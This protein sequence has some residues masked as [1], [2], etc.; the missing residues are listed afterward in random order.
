MKIQQNIYVNFY[1][2]TSKLLFSLACLACFSNLAIANSLENIAFSSMPG[3]KIQ[4]KMEFSEQAPDPKIFTIDVPARIVLDFKDTSLKLKKKKQR[5]GVGMARSVKAVESQGR[6]RVV[7]NLTSLT[8]YKTRIKNNILYLTLNKGNVGSNKY[9]TQQSI[10]DIDFR[11]GSNGE[12]HIIISFNNKIDNI[13][14]RDKGG[15]IVVNMQNVN[16]PQDLERRLDVVDFATPVQLIDT[17][18]Q[19]NGVRMVIDAKGEYDHLG[20]QM[21]NQFTIEIKELTKKQKEAKLKARFGYSGERLSLIFQDIEVRA[22]L[23]LIADFTGKNMVT[24]D[25]V[26]G[27]ITLRLK[28]VPWDQALDLILKTKGLAMREEGNVIRVAPMEELAAIEKQELEANKTIASLLPRVRETIQLNYRRASVV[29]ALL[30]SIGD[31][32]GSKNTASS[33]AGEA[34]TGGDSDSGASLL[35]ANATIIGDDRTNKIIVYDNR[36]NIVQLRKLI[37]EIDVPTKQVLIDSRIVSAG[38][39][40]SRDIGVT[41]QAFN[42]NKIHITDSGAAVYTGSDAQINL[43]NA[44]AAAGTLGISTSILGG[45]WLVDLELQ[46]AET[47][48]TAEIISSPRVVSANGEKAVIKQGVEIPYQTLSDQGVNIEFKEAV[49]QLEVTPN[50]TPNNR[51]EMDVVIKNDSQSGTAVDGTPIIDKQ[52]LSTNVIVNN[53][54]TVVL[55]GVFKYESNKSEQKIPILGDIPIIG[56]AFK[57]SSRLESKRELL[58]FITPKVLDSEVSIRN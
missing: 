58:I 9:A 49:L 26:T 24:S 29:V 44:A 39:T 27:N 52:E 46:A 20:Y 28:N 30:K 57:N 16:L 2:I 14:L 38:D 18:A 42:K 21:G 7:V 12:G 19:G 54:D 37:E 13:T 17:Y 33:G 4:I 51:I 43:G 1:R 6:T 11:R 3:D 31:E 35:S 45:G 36:R 48:G 15:K 50:I 8:D 5:I 10:R 40:F 34:S 53:G 47:D 56:L 22:V 55:G 32:E 23:Q 25:T 41:W